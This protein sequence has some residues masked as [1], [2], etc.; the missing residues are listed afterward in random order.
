M[1]RSRGIAAECQSF[2][3]LR[4]QQDV[5]ISAIKI[6]PCR[7]CLCSCSKYQ[8]AMLQ[9]NRFLPTILVY[10]KDRSEISYEPIDA[11]HFSI[12]IYLYSFMI[13]NTFNNL[14]QVCLWIASMKGVVNVPEITTKFSLFLDQAAFESLVCKR[15][16]CCHSCQPSPDNQSSGNNVNNWFIKWLER[17]APAY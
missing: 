3:K 4:L 8:C 5:L 6:L 9:F 2:L 10:R 15:Q 7:K 17:P 16:G 14:F 1:S 13:L 12:R 11:L